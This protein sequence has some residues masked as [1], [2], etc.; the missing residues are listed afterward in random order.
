MKK[1]KETGIFVEK[2]GEVNFFEIITINS[3]PL[4]YELRNK[5]KNMIVWKDKEKK[6]IRRF[7]KKEIIN[8]AMK[9]V[10][11]NRNILKML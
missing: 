4:Y 5:T 3:E 6:I 11:L 10:E 1:R 7:N 2:N 9:N 8:L